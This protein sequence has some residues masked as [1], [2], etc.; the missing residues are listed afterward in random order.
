MASMIDCRLLPRPEMSTPIERRTNGGVTRSGPPVAR[1]RPRRC[2]TALGSP[3]RSSMSSTRSASRGGAHDDQADAHVERA[4]HLVA[5]DRAALLQQPEDRRHR[6]R[7]AIDL[8]GRSP[9]AGSRGRF[10]VMPPPVMCAMPFTSSRSSSGRIDAQIRAVRRQQ[11]VADGRAE[12]AARTCRPPA[13]PLEE[14]APRQ[15]VAVGVQAGRRQADQ[16]VARHDRS[17]V[18][19]ASTSRRR[20]R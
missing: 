20:R 16:H 10:S 15:R 18:D 11:R 19:D 8:G 7:V 12:L 6:P 14:H 3:L 4:E 9:R 17:A 1:R 2:G 5:R 13:R